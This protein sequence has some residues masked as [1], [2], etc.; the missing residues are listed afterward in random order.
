MPFVNQIESLD[1]LEAAGHLYSQVFT[2]HISPSALT[3]IQTYYDTDERLPYIEATDAGLAQA[4]YDM[5]NSGKCTSVLYGIDGLILDTFSK[6]YNILDG[7]FDKDKFQSGGFV[8]ADAAAGAEE[9]E[10]ETQPTYF[11]SDMVEINGRQYEIMGIVAKITAITEGVNSM[12]KSLTFTSKTTLTKHYKEQ[13]RAN[14]ILGFSISI[15]IAFVGILNFINSMVTA[16]V[17]RQKEFALIQSIGMTKRQL[18]SMLIDEGLMFA[19]ST[20]IA[21]YVLGT[22]AV[23][24]GVRAM[25]SG[26][27]TATYHFTLLPL[28]ICTPVLIIFAIL[29]PYICFKNLEKQRIVERLRA[30]D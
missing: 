19:G 10:K 18:R 11:V 30:V 12:D 23:A 13:T 4:Y 3:N 1:G 2:H 16:I 17:S 15:I 9:S 6:E 20:L 28:I 14:T 7:T 22:L 29:I 24:M 8:F 27:W 26:D 5:I 25:V 21:S